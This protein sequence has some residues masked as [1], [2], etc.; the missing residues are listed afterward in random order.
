MGIILDI[1]GAIFEGMLK[2]GQR[3]IDRMQKDY[4]KASDKAQGYSDERLKQAY[5][6]ASS[7]FEKKAY[8]DE[9]VDRGYGNKKEDK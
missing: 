4:D 3:N 1:L 6:N 8:A 5:K 2:E 7:A 9:L